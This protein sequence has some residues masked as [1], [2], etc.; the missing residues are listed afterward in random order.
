MKKSTMTAAATS[1]PPWR[2]ARA[3]AVG[4]KL[5]TATVRQ[6]TVNGGFTPAAGSMARPTG[7]Q[8]SLYDQVPKPGWRDGR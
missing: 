2:I 7:G 1:E 8:P 4:V 3:S 6:G 5:L